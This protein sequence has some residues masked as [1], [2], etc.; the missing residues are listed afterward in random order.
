MM[1]KIITFMIIFM[2]PSIILT[3]AL[4]KAASKRRRIEESVCKTPHEAY[5]AFNYNNRPKGGHLG[6]TH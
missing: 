3:L 1:M 4:C 5:P 2:T 6:M